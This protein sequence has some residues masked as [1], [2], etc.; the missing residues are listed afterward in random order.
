MRVCP[1]H[2]TRRR[3]RTSYEFMRALDM[4]RSSLTGGNKTLVLSS[5]SPIAQI[6]SGQWGARNDALFA[7]ADFSFDHFD[8]GMK[9]ERQISGRPRALSSSGAS[10]S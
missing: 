7:G 2:M 10:S 6:F 8:I 9:R 4:A 1:R 5:D 3:K